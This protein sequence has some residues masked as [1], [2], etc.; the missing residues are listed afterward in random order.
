MS[1]HKYRI[2]QLSPDCPEYDIE[3][4]ISLLGQLTTRELDLSKERLRRS[5]RKSRIFVARTEDGRMIGMGTLSELDIP[6]GYSGLVDDIVVDENHRGRGNGRKI[7]NRII[8]IALRLG[9]SHLKLT[10][11]PS[12]PDR[13]RA[14]ALYE[15]LGFKV[16]DTNVMALHLSS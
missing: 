4:M 5:I 6:V 10:S 15:S 7:C 14:V 9:M 11:N 12:N 2:E 8:A 3:A 1:A 16:Y 13:L